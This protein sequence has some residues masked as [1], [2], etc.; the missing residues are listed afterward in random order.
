TPLPRSTTT[1]GHLGKRTRDCPLRQHPRRPGKRR[2]ERLLKA[3][4]TALNPSPLELQL[5]VPCISLAQL[6]LSSSAQLLLALRET[7]PGHPTE[8][9]PLPVPGWGAGSQ[10]CHV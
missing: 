8:E 2:A 5:V 10:A 4:Q 3:A 6:L 7:H 9:V 1:P